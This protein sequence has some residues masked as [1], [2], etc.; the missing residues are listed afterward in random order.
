MICEADGVMECLGAWYCT[1]H[2]ESGFLAVA[3]YLARMRGW[4]E[5]ET[6]EQLVTWLNS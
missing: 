6:E 2:L 5:S 3:N 4:D 1:E